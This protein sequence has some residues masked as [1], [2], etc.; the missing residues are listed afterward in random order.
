MIFEGN[1]DVDG[2]SSGIIM[3]NAGSVKFERR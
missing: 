1:N 3:Y 2:V